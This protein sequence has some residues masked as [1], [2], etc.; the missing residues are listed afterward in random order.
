MHLQPRRLAIGDIFAIG[1]KL[2]KLTRG[3]EQRCGRDLAN[4]KNIEQAVVDACARSDLDTAPGLPPI[5]NDCH[6]AAASN[7]APR[8]DQPSSIM[9]KVDRQNRT[10]HSVSGWAKQAFE[11]G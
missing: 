1:W 6:R 4:D 10:H 3:G 9:M 8:Q 7:F 11:F 2:L 5:S